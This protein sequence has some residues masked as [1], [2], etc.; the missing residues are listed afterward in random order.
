MV[1]VEGA[2]FT[3]N[4]ETRKDFQET[5]FYAGK[6]FSKASFGMGKDL[7]NEKPEGERGK[8]GKH[9]FRSNVTIVAGKLEWIG[10]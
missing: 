7:A 10:Y 2:V 6:S 1:N 3:V 8:G 5:E 9:R 4:A